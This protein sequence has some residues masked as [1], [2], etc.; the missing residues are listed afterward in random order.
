[1]PPL[2]RVARIL[3]HLALFLIAILVFTLGTGIG[4]SQNPTYGTLLWI[5]AGLITAANVWWIFRASRPKD[6]GQK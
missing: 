5:A 4:L 1:M 2:S 3:A 6:P